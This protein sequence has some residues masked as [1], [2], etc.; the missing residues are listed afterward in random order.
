MRQQLNFDNTIAKKSLGQNFIK[1][2]NFLL[3]LSSKIKTYSDTNII[4][5][6][7][8]TGA[9]TEHLVKKKFKSLYVIE[10]DRE[11]SDILDKKYKNKSKVKVINQDAL[12]TDYKQFNAKEKNIIVGNLPFN[13]STQLLFKWL[14]SEKWPPF[15]TSMILMFQKEVAKRIISKPKN[16][17]YSRITVSAQTRCNIKKVMDAPAGIFFPKPKVDGVILEFT[18]SLKYQNINFSKLQKILTLSFSQRRK[19]I[20]STLCLHLKE[21]EIAK[22]DKNLR[23]DNL[24]INDY[25]RI[26]ELIS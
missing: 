5:I 4:E 22:I 7:P 21:L 6:G 12:I 2:K 20:K 9:L 11:L 1:D 26:S 16:K 13:V 8:G 24:T 19:K 3:A 18:P 14:E 17:D 23:P 25:C 10:K 15:Y